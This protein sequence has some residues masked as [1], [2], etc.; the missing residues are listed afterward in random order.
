MNKHVKTIAT[1]REREPHFREH[2]R[3]N[4]FVYPKQNNIKKFDK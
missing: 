1:V 4:V 2:V 3:A